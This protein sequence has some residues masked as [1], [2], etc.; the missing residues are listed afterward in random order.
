MNNLTKEQS[1]KIVEGHYRKSYSILVNTLTKK[2]GGRQNAEDTVQEAYTRALTYIKSYDG[3]SDF[4]AWFNTILVNSLSDNRVQVRNRGHTGFDH[5]EMIEDH[6][7][8]DAIDGVQVDE[9]VNSIKSKEKDIKK[10]LT[11]YFIHQYK[12]REI[13]LLVPQTGN[14]IRKIVQRFKEEM[15]S[16]H[17]ET[18]SVRP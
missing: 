16:E 11:L 17:N 2:A 15:A 3:D 6:M 9:I 12:P 1:Y 14:N 4:G 7:K 13:S 8:S 5:V 10:I 18:G